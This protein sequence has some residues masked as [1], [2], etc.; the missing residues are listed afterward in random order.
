MVPTRSMLAQ[1]SWN[2]WNAVMW[3][4]NVLRAHI[5]GMARRRFHLSSALPTPGVASAEVPGPAVAKGACLARRHTRS[6]LWPWGRSC[7][8]VLRMQTLVDVMTVRNTSSLRRRL[9]WTQRTWAE[10]SLWGPELFSQPE[11]EA[12]STSS[13]GWENVLT[14]GVKHCICVWEQQKY[15]WPIFLRWHKSFPWCYF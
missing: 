6:G 12:A 13:A 3:H 5:R 11:E 10:L 2:V 8:A 9:G 7:S 4:A 1:D 14:A 15:R